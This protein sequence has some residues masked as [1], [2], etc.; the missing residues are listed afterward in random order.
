MTSSQDFYI[1]STRTPRFIYGTAWKEELTRELT[2][3][4]LQHGF[5]GIDTANQR[6]HYFEQGVGEALQQHYQESNRTRADL[7]LQTK[8][9]YQ[10]GQDDR[11]P[12]DPSADLTTQVQQSFESSLEHLN[13][14]Y[15]DAFLLHGP[16][17]NDGL[18]DADFEV[19]QAMENLYREGRIKL[20][21]I[22][23]VSANQLEY[24][25]HHTAIKPTLVQNRCFAINGWDQQV[26]QLCQR[27]DIV[28]QGFSLLT[29]NLDITRHSDF[30]NIVMRSGLTA[31]QVIFQFALKVG[32]IVLTGTKDQHHMKEDLNCEASALNKEDVKRIETL[33]MPDYQA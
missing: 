4:A 18:S 27:H 2:L 16:S 33:L 20:L 11:L 12:Y 15:L 26:R 23:N 22:S 13:T 10:N 1:N 25:N 17:L 28:Y 3:K 30:Q 31:A 8:F 6:K 24:L 7:F 29:A 9:T 19:W 14:D 21:G 32:M 5:T